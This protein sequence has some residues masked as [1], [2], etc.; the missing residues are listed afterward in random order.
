MPFSYTPIL[1][2]EHHDETPWRLLTKDHV[3]T[4]T[5][6]GKTFLKV[7][8]EALTLLTHAAM[9]DALA[10]GGAAMGTSLLT[11]GQEFLKAL[12][13]VALATL[14]GGLLAGH[15][16]GTVIGIVSLAGVAGL[17]GGE[18]AVCPDQHGVPRLRCP[19]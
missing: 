7:A 17:I 18:A 13:P 9:N 4:F 6:D 5:A 16:W 8:P 14:A 2:L 15:G 10:M 3:S 1:P 11:Q 12:V 19:Q